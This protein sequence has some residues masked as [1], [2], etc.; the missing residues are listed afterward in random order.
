MDIN[1][2]RLNRLLPYQE[3]LVDRRQRE[4]IWGKWDTNMNGV[5]SLK[6][7]EQEFLQMFNL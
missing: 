2:D 4:E 1:Y 5:L 3:C 7:I 6:E